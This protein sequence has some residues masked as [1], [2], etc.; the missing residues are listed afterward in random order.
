MCVD[1]LVD[2]NV[3]LRY[4]LFGLGFQLKLSIGVG[5]D[6]WSDLNFGCGLHVGVGV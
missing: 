1:M 3:D 2:V 5:M 6:M 4:E